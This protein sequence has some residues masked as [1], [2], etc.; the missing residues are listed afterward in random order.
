M[1]QSA[2]EFH[3]PIQKFLLDLGIVGDSF[4]ELVELYNAIFGVSQ[5]HAAYGLHQLEIR[6]LLVAE[7]SHIAQPKK[8]S[9]KILRRKK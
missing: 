6:S 7:A 5:S 9:I 8:S 4:R 3:I 2:T 1:R